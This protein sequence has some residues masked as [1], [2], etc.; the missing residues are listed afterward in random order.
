MEMYPQLNVDRGNPKPLSDQLTQSLRSLILRGVMQAGDALPSSRSLAQTL[1]VSRSVTVSAYERLVGEGYLESRQG[2]GTRV[3]GELP[4]WVADP[5]SGAAPVAPGSMLRARDPEPIHSPAE[6]LTPIDLRPGRPFT[7]PTPPRE[8]VRALA[9]ASRER[10]ESDAPDPCGAPELRRVIA[11]HARRSRGIDCDASDVVVTTG[12]SEA[13]VVVALALR[14]LRGHGPRIVVEDPGYV[15]GA[16]ALKRAGATL[17]PM[18]V[19]MDGATAA[20]LRSLAGLVDAVMLT[21]GHQYPLGGRIPAIERLGILTWADEVDAF[22]IED[23]YDSE[24]R[25]DGAVLPAMASLNRS[26]QVIHVSTF[27]K[28]L[29]PSLRCGAIVL[30]KGDEAASIRAAVRSVRKDLGEAV[31]LIIQRALARFLDGG[32]F[33]REVGRIK[34]EYRHRRAML[35]DACVRRG[36]T[37]TG[38]DGGL[39]VVI[40]LKE[41]SDPKRVALE[42]EHRGVRV[43]RVQGILEGVGA[44]SGSGYDCGILVG[45]GAESVARMLQGV[46]EIAD[47]VVP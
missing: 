39:H 4:K 41:G 5:A 24:F 37:V 44:D 31:P 38:A 20:G 10:W 47:V 11:D 12:T 28:V 21:P 46:S 34:R 33:R 19:G 40:A 23:D 45:Y 17:I 43:G 14:E 32:G 27:N 36:L 9:M 22:L 35:L 30:G 26:G 8:W 13:L 18:P 6:A 25:H 3:A 42:L 16:R 1:G 29:S 2:S 15:E 7:S